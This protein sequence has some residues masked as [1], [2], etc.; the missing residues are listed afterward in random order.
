MTEHKW[1]RTP[2]LDDSDNFGYI[3]FNQIAYV[4]SVCKYKIFTSR[5]DGLVVKD[6]RDNRNIWDCDLMIISGVHNT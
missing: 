5:P 2:E 6:D 4:C 1:T 3:K